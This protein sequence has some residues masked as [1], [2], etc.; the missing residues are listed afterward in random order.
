[1]SAV[2]FIFC[3][4]GAEIR[5]NERNFVV[6][7]N[8]LAVTAELVRINGQAHY[9]DFYTA[10]L[11]ALH[12]EVKDLLMAEK[13]EGFRPLP[14]SYIDISEK[15]MYLCINLGEYNTA[16]LLRFAYLYCLSENQIYFS[17]LLSYLTTGDKQFYTFIEENFLQPWSITQFAYQFGMPTRKF[18]AIFLKKFGVSAKI[19][20]LNRR[21]EYAK[22][23]L[24]T[25]SMRILDVA[26]ECGF[27][28]HAHFTSSFHQHFHLTP[29]G[30]RQHI[31]M[32]LT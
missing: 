6:P 26:L 2:R 4:Y 13:R 7:T 30:F 21:L 17:G 1:M 3:P 22:Q 9:F 28:N 32:T 29:K 20:L 19:W 12:H 27:S 14:I 24:Q 5:I 25:T 23:L 31:M 11:Q 16:A 18:N 15:L 10:D 8:H